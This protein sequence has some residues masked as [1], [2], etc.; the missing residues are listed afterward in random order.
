MSLVVRQGKSDTDRGS[1]ERKERPRWNWEKRE[2]Q[3]VRMRQERNGK[4]VIIGGKK[5]WKG[6]TKDEKTPNMGFISL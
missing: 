3:K 1:T 4:L 2:K 5:E 6:G